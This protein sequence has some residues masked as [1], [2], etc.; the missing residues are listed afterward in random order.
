MLCCNRLMSIID[1]IPLDNEDIYYNRKIYV[2]ECPHCKK[3]KFQLTEINSITGCVEYD[4]NKPK[5]IKNEEA[6]L[7]NLL[8]LS[9]DSSLKIKKGSK[10]AMAFIFGSNKVINKKPIQIGYDFNGT[11]RNRTEAKDFFCGVE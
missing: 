9:Y 6:W 2:R 5:R 11:E 7:N 10:S 1:T 4:R 3:R 8:K